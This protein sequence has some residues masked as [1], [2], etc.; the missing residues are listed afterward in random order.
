MLQWTAVTPLTVIINA[1]Q[2]GLKAVI[3]T[4]VFQALIML[5]G[6]LSVVIKGSANA[7]GFSNAWQTCAEHGRIDFIQ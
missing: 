1:F 4:D 6:F 3:W 2:G 5:A 7:G